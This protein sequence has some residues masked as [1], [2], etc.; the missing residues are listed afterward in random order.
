MDCPPKG[1]D[2]TKKWESIHEPHERVA[3]AV[4]F[5][6]T[7]YPICLLYAVQTDEDGEPVKELGEWK[8]HTTRSLAEVLAM[9]QSAVSRAILYLKSRHLLDDSDEAFCLDLSPKSLSRIER[10]SCARGSDSESFGILL[11]SARKILSQ[12]LAAISADLESCARLKQIATDACAQQNREAAEARARAAKAVLES[13][14]PYLSLLSRSGE[15]EK[16]LRA[17]GVYNSKPAQTRPPAPKPSHDGLRDPAAKE[18]YEAIPALQAPYPHS[19][20]SRSRFSMGKADLELVS[21]I[22][23]KLEPTG[24]DAEG[25]VRFVWARFRARRSPNDEGGPRKLGLLIEWAGDYAAEFAATPKP[26]S[27]EEKK[28]LEAQAVLANPDAGFDKETIAWA[29][30]VIEGKTKGAGS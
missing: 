8:R 1:W 24:Y 22:L 4:E 25:F 3:A 20:F 15:A 30:G 18:L 28:L 6:S 27:P 10:E 9:S 19:A 2:R 13:C 16:D 12:I 7:C 23:D 29:Q 11:P 17:G 26:V 21:K 5:Y 14:Q